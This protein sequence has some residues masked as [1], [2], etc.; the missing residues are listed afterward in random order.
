MR[1]YFGSGTTK[2][3]L[4]LIKVQARLS[5]DETGCRNFSGNCRPKGSVLT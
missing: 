3:R 1:I 2:F 4:L 5:R